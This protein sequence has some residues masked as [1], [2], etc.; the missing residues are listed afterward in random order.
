MTRFLESEGV[1]NVTNFA[2]SIFA[3]AND[4]QPLQQN[5]EQ[6]ATV[7]PYNWIWGWRYLDEALHAEDY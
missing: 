5:G 2:G 6:A 3:W 4:G 1:A 7:H